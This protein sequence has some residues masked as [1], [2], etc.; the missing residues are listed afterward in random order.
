MTEKGIFRL[1]EH[2]TLLGK[3]VFYLLF[4]I[5]F[6]ATEIVGEF[7]RYYFVVLW[8]HGRGWFWLTEKVVKWLQSF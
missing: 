2:H 7:T 3:F 1:A 4:R 8:S 5:E 6:N